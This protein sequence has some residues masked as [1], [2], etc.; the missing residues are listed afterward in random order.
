MEHSRNTR[1]RGETTLRHPLC[2][3]R[4]VA[5]G[6]IYAV[7]RKLPKQLLLLGLTHNIVAVERAN[8]HTIVVGIVRTNA[9]EANKRKDQTRQ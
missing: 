1:L 2:R 8:T 9:I 4:I 7:A 3:Y 5:I 6:A